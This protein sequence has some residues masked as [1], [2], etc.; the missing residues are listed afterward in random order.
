MEYDADFWLKA[1]ALAWAVG[2][3]VVGGY[4]NLLFA[5]LDRAD[6]AFNEFCKSTKLE[7][8]QLAADRAKSVGELRDRMATFEAL[9]MHA[10]TKDDFHDL[11]L[12]VEKLGGEVSK[13]SVIVGG[14]GETVTRIDRYLLDN[15]K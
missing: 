12:H 5:R 8:E 2:T 7:L 13:V 15:S 4:I 10:P 3:V 9:I 14:F 11:A 1:V 6:R